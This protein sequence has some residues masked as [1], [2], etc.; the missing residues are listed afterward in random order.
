MINRTVYSKISYL[1]FQRF[2]TNLKSDKQKIDSFYDFMDENI[3]VKGK[4]FEN[5]IIDDKNILLLVLKC[6]M[7]GSK[8]EACE[9]GLKVAVK[10]LN[11]TAF[12]LPKEKRCFLHKR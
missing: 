10:Y 6:P 2:C 7:T 1:C 9:E 12:N 4:K 8:L 3:K 11:K 5:K